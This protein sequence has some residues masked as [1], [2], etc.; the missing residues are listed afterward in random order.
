M[1]RVAWPA[2]RLIPPGERCYWDAA[3]DRP[4]HTDPHSA[5]GRLAAPMEGPSEEPYPR[6]ASDGR[7]WLG[8]AGARPCD[9]ALV[10]EHDGLDAIA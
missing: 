2:L 3:A 7:L 1:N 4:T 10:G 8:L 6:K 5:E 9:P